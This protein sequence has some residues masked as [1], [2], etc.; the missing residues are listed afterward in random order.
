MFAVF[1]F[2]SAVQLLVQLLQYC[3]ELTVLISQPFVTLPSQSDQPGLHELITHALATH[4][5][6]LTL[7]NFEQLLPHAAQAD[8]V[9]VR[10][11]SQP[12]PGRPLQSPV[13]AVQFATKQT[14]LMHFGTLTFTGR[15][16]AQSVVH[17]PH[18]VGS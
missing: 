6:S 1:T 14:P 4:A 8:A 12:S 13:P 17:R 5:V 15:T 2:G 16:V 3:V 9:D 18:L 7:A 11:A 10:S